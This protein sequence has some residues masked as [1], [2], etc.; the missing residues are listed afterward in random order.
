MG[1][2]NELIGSSIRF[3]LGATSTAEMI[4]KAVER[5]VKVAAAWQGAPAGR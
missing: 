1:L 3:S 5:I 2:S 4:D